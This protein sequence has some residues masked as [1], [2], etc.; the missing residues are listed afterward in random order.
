MEREELLR[1]L[2]IFSKSQVRAEVKAEA[3]RHLTTKLRELR[4]LL[5]LHPE[6]EHHDEMIYRVGGYLDGF[7]DASNLIEKMVEGLKPN[8]EIKE[9][10]IY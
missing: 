7:E 10:P 3:Q 6:L 9:K 4:A 8:E 1:E 2:Q 5:S